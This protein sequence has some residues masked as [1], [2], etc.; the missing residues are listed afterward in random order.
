[1]VLGGTLILSALLTVCSVDG[2]KALVGQRRW[3]M[4]TIAGDGGG[5][6][7]DGSGIN[8]QF[9]HPSGVAV[10][11]DGN[12]YIAD[13]GN[14]RIRKITPEGEVSTVAGDGTAAYRDHATDAR[15]AQFH[16]P[17]D[18]AM[19]EVGNLYIADQN[20]HRIR[21]ITPEGEVSTLAGS[22]L[23]FRDASGTSAQFSHPSGVA[24]DKDGNLYIADH[25]NNRIRKISPS[26]EVTTI[27]GN[28]S[29]GHRDHT[30]GTEAQFAHPRGVEVD[31]NGNVYVADYGNHRI[32][33]ISPEGEVSTLAG[34][35]LIG[36]FADGSSSQARFH[37][38][39]ELVMDGNGNI[40]VTDSS[41]HR[42]RKIS[43]EGEVSTL[44]GA[45]QG[46]H[47]DVGTDAQLSRPTGLVIDNNA[48]L[49]ITDFENNRIRKLEYK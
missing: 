9:H 36:D 32:R 18:V 49:Y 26:A 46:Y 44:A 12:L 13:Q 27:A 25:Y 10:D 35:G 7:A 38:P 23:G 45:E 37:N 42:I 24:V 11:K 22:T 34:G 29:M 33:K 20:N 28:G 1:M 47:D 40:Y 21:K 43:P 15:M 5:G 4:T 8:A 17:A 48:N 30:I 3:Q 19:D 16:R 2:I 41:N 31:K 14:Q 39:A 6:F